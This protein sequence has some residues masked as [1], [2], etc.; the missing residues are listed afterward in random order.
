MIDKNIF[1]KDIDFQGVKG[2]VFLGGK[3]IVFRRDNNTKNFPLQIDLPGGGREDQ[4]SPFETFK[5][6]VNEEFGINIEK[7]DIV[8]AKKYQSILD[9]SK[10][11]Y[12]FATKSLNIKEN[13][14]VFSD[15]GLEFFL[16]TPQGFINTKDGVRRQQDKV[17][18]FLENYGK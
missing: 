2:L 9:L 16:V 18:Y 11:A 10:D 13:Q 14:I 3:I 4:E 8:Y 7:K 5:R 12:F 15:E 6:E 17:A 1:N